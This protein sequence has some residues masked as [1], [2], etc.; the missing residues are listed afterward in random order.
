MD[1]CRIGGVVGDR[2]VSEGR[3]RFNNRQKCPLLAIRDSLRTAGKCPITA[4]D[5]KSPAEAQTGA[6][7][8]VD[9][10]HS[11]ASRCHRVVALEQTTLRG[12]VHG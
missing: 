6:F 10:A 3:F 7:D 5:R 2:R 9:G 8:A 4:L 11:S 12:A 1:L